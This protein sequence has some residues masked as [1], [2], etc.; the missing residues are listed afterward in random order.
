MTSDLLR[1]HKHDLYYP[2]ISSSSPYL[3]LPGGSSSSP[4]KSS[5]ATPS[6]TYPFVILPNLDQSTTSPALSCGPN[7][8]DEAQLI[9]TVPIRAICCI[10]TVRHGQHAVHGSTWFKIDQVGRKSEASNAWVQA[11]LMT[12]AS[13]TR[14]PP[15]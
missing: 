2:Q 7:A 5:M 9:S 13:A 12:G 1:S 14:L 3:S 4:A 10:I 11:D 8:G 6:Q 15:H